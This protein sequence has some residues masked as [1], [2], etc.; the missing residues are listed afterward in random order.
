MPGNMARE[1]TIQKINQ[2]D[3]ILMRF[4]SRH[5]VCNRGFAEVRENLLKAA[6]DDLSKILRRSGF[7]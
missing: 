7:I 3:N 5:E 4:D 1:E 2:K 6:C